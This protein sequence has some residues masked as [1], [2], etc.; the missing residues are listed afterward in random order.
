[1]S[2]VPRKFCALL[3][4]TDEQLRGRVLSYINT[5]SWL[6]P[7]TL[8][9]APHGAVDLRFDLTFL[10]IDAGKSGPAAKFNAPRSLGDDVVHIIFTDDPHGCAASLEGFRGRIHILP[11][12]PDLWESA[13]RPLISSIMKTIEEAGSS[14]SSGNVPPGQI[15]KR[16]AFLETMTRAMKESSSS[17]GNLEEML[18]GALRMILT[19]MEAEKGSIML[20][21]DSGMLAV[22]ASTNPAIIGVTQSIAD[23]AIASISARNNET[24][25]IE[26]TGSGGTLPTRGGG[27]YKSGSLIAFPIRFQG[28]VKG[29]I[30]VTD[31]N[32]L[33]GFSPDDESALSVF[34][35][36][37]VTAM[38]SAEIRRDRDK[39]KEMHARLSELQLFKE[40]MIQ[41][42]VHDLK[43]PVGVI[44]SNIGMLLDEVKDDFQ[45]EVLD[46]AN[47]SAEELLRMVM[48]IL[49]VNKMEEGKFSISPEDMDIV[50]LGRTGLERIRAMAEG[51]G[52]NVAFETDSPSLKIQAD[53]GLIG[54][55]I[56]NLLSNANNHTSRGGK[57]TLKTQARDSGA[58]I[59]VA[60]TGTGIS[61]DDA[62]RIFDKFYQAGNR[63]VKYST[64][65]GLT[66][67]KMAVEAHG[68]R[69]TVESEL[70]KG[71]RFTIAL[72]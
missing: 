41:M 56:W 37:I 1:M 59:T 3:S 54:R 10:E 24:I 46:S 48:D 4:I 23:N 11:K 34:A 72:P 66:F 70:G 62:K 29:V 55:V 36:V 30:N 38:L 15:A 14:R 27:V 26:N 16:L 64:G 68:G 42:L 35:G 49:D 7:E 18:N 2:Q 44:I 9:G 69:I 40:N 58:V 28:E 61:E 63:H 50:E 17:R 6:C 12:N 65:L 43:G 60:D 8:P 13:V 21:D 71:S 47:S 33:S 57:I 52:K 5:T 31:K 51:D 32:D 19:G 25:I 53:K 20:L 67:C 22:R 45:K 39:F